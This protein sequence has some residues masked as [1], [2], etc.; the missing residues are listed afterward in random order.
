MAVLAPPQTD[1]E[2]LFANTG[3]AFTVT[4]IGVGRA[5]QPAADVAVTLYT[6][7]PGLPLP[8]FV[9][10]WAI[11]PPLPPLA[12]VTPPV[13][14][15]VVQLN[16]LG[17]AVLAAKKISVLVL[18]QITYALLLVTAGEALT[19]TATGV[20]KAARQPAAEVGVTLYTTLPDSVSLGFARVWFIVPPVPAAS[21][22]MPPV[23][24]P[25]THENVLWPAALAVNAIPGLA[26]RCK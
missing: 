1:A 6:T 21:P 22:V 7:V 24:L 8:G 4:V 12:P 5:R 15:P 2:S 23:I 20:A 11:M 26:R 25:T 13:T 16:V 9:N 18:L 10:I 14:A 19:V 17:P 3:K